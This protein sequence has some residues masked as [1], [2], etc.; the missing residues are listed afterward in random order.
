V[1]PEFLGNTGKNLNR[2]LAHE[3][4]SARRLVRFAID[5]A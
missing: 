1:N 3:A 4:V 2:Q 5:W